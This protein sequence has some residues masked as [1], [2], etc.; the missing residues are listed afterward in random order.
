MSRLTPI[1]R[2]A[3]DSYIALS[4]AALDNRLCLTRCADVRTGLPAFV[5]CAIEQHDGITDY[6]PLARLFNGN[7]SNEVTSPGVPATRL[8]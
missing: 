7:P 2:K 8:I 3:R 1:P 5:I 6:I 4:E